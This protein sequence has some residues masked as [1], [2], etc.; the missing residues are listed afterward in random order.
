MRDSVGD[1]RH[2]DLVRG[3]LSCEERSIPSQDTP[4]EDDS[5][6]RRVVRFNEIAAIVD[7]V[8]PCDD[9]NRVGC[10]ICPARQEFAEPDRDPGEGED[11]PT[12][13]RPPSAPGTFETMPPYSPEFVAPEDAEP[14]DAWPRPR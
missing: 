3:C 2:E 8:V 4:T 5:A 12:T 6:D 13:E 14:G 7:P 11:E 9:H 1:C 10:D